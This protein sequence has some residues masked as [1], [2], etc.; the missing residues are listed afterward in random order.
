M[1][2][3]FLFPNLL[4]MY[5]DVLNKLEKLTSDG[6]RGLLGT[7]TGIYGHI[8]SLETILLIVEI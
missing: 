2:K 5:I 1:Q 6:T 3:R 4:L 8:G 7:K